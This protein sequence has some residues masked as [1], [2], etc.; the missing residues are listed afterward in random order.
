M[1]L[2]VSPTLLYDNQP[3]VVDVQPVA[4]AT[5]AAPFEFDKLDTILT[6][7]LVINF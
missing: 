4:P 1:A 2:K 6:A 5:A 7:A 3:V